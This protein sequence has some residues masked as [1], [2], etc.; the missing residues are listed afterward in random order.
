M[1]RTIVAFLVLALVT[2]G[3]LVVLFR[4]PSN[5]KTWKDYLAVPTN[6]TFSEDGESVTLSS[7][8]DWTYNEEEAVSRTYVD[9]TYD[10]G[11]VSGLWFVVEPFP[12]MPSFGHTLLVFEFTDAPPIAFSVEALLEEGEN[13]SAWKG[14]FNEYELAY[15]W[16][17][18]RDFLTRRAVMLGHEIYRYQLAVSPEVAREVF[19]SFLKGTQTLAERPVF[20][21]TLLHNCT[22]ELAHLINERTPGALPWDWS[23]VFTGTADQYLYKLGYITG[24]SFKEA[25]AAAR[26][27][28]R[29]REL[30]LDPAFSEKL[31]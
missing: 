13:Y 6:V 27:T 21:N 17:T 14:L 1:I 23:R 29:V 7:V 12:D 3:V 9:R 22:N 18:E 25:Q 4:Q 28:E 20:Y 24:S 26:I 19:V 11:S 15:T 2:G 5:E 30:S 10:L 8:R 31:R 16:G